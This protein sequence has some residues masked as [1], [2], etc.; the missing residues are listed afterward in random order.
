MTF[1]DVSDNNRSDTVRDLFLNATTKWGWPQRVRA[2]YGSENLGVKAEMESRRGER[3]FVR[4]SH[5]LIESAHVGRDNGAFLQGTSTRNQRIE[6]LWVNV[7]QIVVDKYIKIFR[8]LED[9]YLLGTDDPLHLYCLHFVYL[10][11][12]KSSI[13]A[14]VAAWNNHS[15]STPGLGNLSPLAQYYMGTLLTR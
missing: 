3:H 2:D 4:T 7:R 5:L 11:M 1:I 8:D 10:P 14:W 9:E 12:I 6:R 13:Q 15:M